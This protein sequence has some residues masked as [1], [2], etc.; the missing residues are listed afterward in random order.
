A[1][2]AVRPSG[3][4]LVFW[5]CYRPHD[6]QVRLFQVVPNPAWVARPGPY[7]RSHEAA[8]SVDLTVA[9]QP[10]RCPPEHRLA[11]RC[12]LDM[13]T[14]FD[15]FTDR[16]TAFAT[17]GVSAA[18][19]ENR[20]HLRQEMSAGGLTFCAATLLRFFGLAAKERT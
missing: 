4:M 19:Q 15:D 6:A 9:G 20:A 12:L 13:G 11:G 1:A 7:A 10:D 16:A 8:R 3:Q 17:A 18:A 2:D 5:D 14:D